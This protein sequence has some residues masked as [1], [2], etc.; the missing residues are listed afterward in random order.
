MVQPNPYIIVVEVMEDRIILHLGLLDQL[1]EEEPHADRRILIR[2]LILIIVVDS[3][4]QV[5]VEVEMIMVHSLNIL[6][7]PIGV[8]EEEGD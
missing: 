7:I 2:I 8:V 3:I 4:P 6:Y 5:V 1:A